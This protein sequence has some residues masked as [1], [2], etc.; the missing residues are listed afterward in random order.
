MIRHLGSGQS[1]RCF[2]VLRYTPHDLA[3]DTIFRIQHDPLRPY[4]RA[5][6]DTM[7]FN[8]K[9]SVELNKFDLCVAE[10]RICEK[11]LGRRPSC[12]QGII[13]NRSIRECCRGDLSSLI[14]VRGEAVADNSVIE[15]Y[16]S[17]SPNS[18]GRS[19]VN[20]TKNISSPDRVDKEYFVGT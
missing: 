10:G 13:D 20:I 17:L 8:R 15:I 2:V 3:Y 12:F 18:V 6:S 19:R 1:V 7:S 14:T 5:L 4:R 9:S 11:G 16:C